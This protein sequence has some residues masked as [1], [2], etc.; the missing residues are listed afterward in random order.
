[1]TGVRELEERQR[2][3][4]K[5]SAR[6]NELKRKR[7]SLNENAELD[8]G[9]KKAKFLF[10]ELKSTSLNAQEGKCILLQYGKCILL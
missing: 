5:Q 1:M 10:K 4:G 8:E 2:C 6:L 7:E 9:V 3:V